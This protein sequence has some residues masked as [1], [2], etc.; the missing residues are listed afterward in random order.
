MLLEHHEQQCHPRSVPCVL[1]TWFQ[2]RFQARLK[3]TSSK[4]S[5]LLVLAILFFLGVVG[6]ECK[7]DVELSLSLQE[8]L[9][10]A[11]V[12]VVFRVN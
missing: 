6:G 3:V 5:I 9:A 12:G 7:Q 2:A 1:P 8:F 4:P 10:N 11:V